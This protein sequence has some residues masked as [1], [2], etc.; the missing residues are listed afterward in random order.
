MP[1]FFSCRVTCSMEGGSVWSVRE[2]GG[3]GERREEETV[4]IHRE[5]WGNK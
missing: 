2:V 4:W 3:G 5:D 1:V